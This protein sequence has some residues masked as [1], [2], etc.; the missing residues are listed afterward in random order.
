MSEE[1]NATPQETPKD[2]QS[3]FP[4]NIPNDPSLLLVRGKNG[5]NKPYIKTLAHATLTVVAKY[6]YASLKCVGASA[7]NNAMKAIVIASG[8]AKKRGINLVISPSFQEA[9]FDG[10]EKT[11]IMLSVFDR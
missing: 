1:T 5:E 11:A 9:N 3:I 2:G 4:E 7:V 6:G 10:V 8:E